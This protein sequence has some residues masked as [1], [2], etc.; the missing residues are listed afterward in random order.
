MSAPATFYTVTDAE[1]FPGT[2]ALLN[3]LRLVGHREPL[4]VLD[5]GL[6]PE[7]RDAAR[8]GCH[9][10]GGSRGI[11]FDAP[12]DPEAVSAPARCD[13]HGGDHRQRHDR[14]RLAG[15]GPFAG[16]RRQDLPLR[17]LRT[18]RAIALDGSRSGTS[19]LRSV[20]R[21]AGSRISTTASSSSR[22]NSGRTSWRT[23]G[24]PARA[25]LPGASSR[26]ESTPCASAT[27]TR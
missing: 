19:S 8:P 27:R 26:A 25:Y 14:L 5:N 4:V 3:S 11:G 6:T 22:P 15:A 17:V 1:F 9:G 24:W 20:P 12:A 13:R 10:R 23:G 7:Q 2:V 18:G 16:A 21:S